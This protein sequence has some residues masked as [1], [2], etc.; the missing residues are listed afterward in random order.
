MARGII[1]MRHYQS[2]LVDYRG[3]VEDPNELGGPGPNW[4]PRSTFSGGT[5]GEAPPFGNKIVIN[6][7]PLTKVDTFR[8]SRPVTNPIIAIFSLGSV[9]QLAQLVFPKSYSLSLESGG[10][11]TWYGGSSIILNGSSVSGMEGNGTIQLNGTFL[12]IHFV[13]P[14]NEYSYS[15]TVGIPRE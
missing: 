10:P 5:V 9:S 3:E 14:I 11:S 13:A 15:I 1:A 4:T 6:G 2:V 7:G 12:A 8:F